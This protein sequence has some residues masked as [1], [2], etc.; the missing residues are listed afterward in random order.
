MSLTFTFTLNLFIGPEENETAFEFLFREKCW[1]I[2]TGHD[3]DYLMKTEARL[4]KSQMKIRI[5][6]P[7]RPKIF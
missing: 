6:F 5:R 3:D 7:S 4:K 2:F 1:K